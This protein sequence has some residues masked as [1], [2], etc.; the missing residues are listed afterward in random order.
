MYLE[1][2]GLRDMPNTL[3]SQMND[4]EINYDRQSGIIGLLRGMLQVEALHLGM[5]IFQSLKVFIPKYLNQ[6]TSKTSLFDVVHK[7]MQ[8]QLIDTQFEVC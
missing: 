1:N 2:L 7:E 6:T 8:L 4:K 5:I 3:N